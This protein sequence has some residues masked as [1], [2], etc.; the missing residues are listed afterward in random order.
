[1]LSL[2]LSLPATTQHDRHIPMKQYRPTRL[3]VNSL[4][5]H[6][7]FETETEAIAFFEEGIKI[8]N[9]LERFDK[10]VI[11]RVRDGDGGNEGDEGFALVNF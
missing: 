10:L 1:M 5:L 6:F 9:H 4:G 3:I 2:F 11:H 7:E 8:G